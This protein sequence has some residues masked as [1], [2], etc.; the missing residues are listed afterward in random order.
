MSIIYALFDDGSQSVKKALEPLGHTVYSFGIQ[1]KETV[2]H[3]DLTN[4]EGFFDKVSNLPAP[5]FIIANPPCE[6][7]SIASACSY[8]NGKSGN[9]YYFYENAEPINDFEIWRNSTSSNIKRMKRDKKEYFEN[10]R[11]KR[12]ISEKLHENTDVIIKHFGVPYIIENPAKSLAWKKYHLGSVRNLTH[13]IAYDENFTKKPT[14][15]ASNI[16]LNLKIADKGQKQK[17]SW[18]QTRNYNNRA[19]LPTKLIV[20]A[21]DELENFILDKKT[22]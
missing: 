11:I 4:L 6:T 2:I 22:K 1:E 20:E 17:K 18:A 9:L 12:I 15:F 10:L 3:C 13:Y 8:P 21:F 16:K 14:I 5:D 7:F 19:S